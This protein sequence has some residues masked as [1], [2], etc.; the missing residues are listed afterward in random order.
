MSERFTIVALILKYIYYK[1]SKISTSNFHLVRLVPLTGGPS[2][3]PYT[4]PISLSSIE[5]L[6]EIQTDQSEFQLDLGQWL[7]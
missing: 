5:I 4:S 1:M 6:I 2:Y 3:I 7:V